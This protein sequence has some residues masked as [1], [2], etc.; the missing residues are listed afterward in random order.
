[1]RSKLKAADFCLID[2]HAHLELEP[3]AENPG[4]YLERARAHG[5]VAVVSVGIDLEDAARNLAIAQAYDQ[6]FACVGFHPHNASVVSDTGLTHMESLA[7]HPKVV[8][9]GEVGLDF[10]RN[11]S[12]QDSQ[13]DAFRAQ[14]ALAKKL[15]LP[16]VIHLRDAYPE[17]LSI[18]ESE[19]PFEKGGV[20]HCFSGTSEHA[21][22][23]VKLGFHISIPGTVTYKKNEALRRIVGEIPED[24]ILVE[25]DCPYLS[26]EPF[27]GKDNEPAHVIYT[28]KKV[29]EIRGM[30]LKNVA[31]ITTENACALFGLYRERNE[32]SGMTRFHI[33]KLQQT[34]EW[35]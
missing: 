9:Y 3:L 7:R 24:R 14:I 33:R 30:S 12:P 28:A 1:M 22:R 15:S 25:T 13:R 10:F 18:L 5:V 16:L 31:D 21:D 27:R 6:V 29:A 35:S 34:H 32:D 26:P 23:V 19:A 20:V 17:G 8:G 11:L 4:K 2:A